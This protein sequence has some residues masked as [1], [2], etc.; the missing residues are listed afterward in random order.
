MHDRGTRRLGIVVI[1]RDQGP[2][3][4]EALAAV[5][6]QGVPWVYVDSGSSD[7]SVEVAGRFEGAIVECLD[8]ALPFT[9]ARGRHH[10]FTVLRERV[11]ELQWVQFVDGDCVLH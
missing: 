1:G 9:A 7:G 8:P 4:G 2:R 10:G 3:L 11:P 5:V 6:R